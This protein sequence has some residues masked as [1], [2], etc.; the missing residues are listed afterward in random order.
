MTTLLSRKTARDALVVLFEATGLWEDVFGYVPKDSA[1]K[2]RSPIMFIT[3]FGTDQTMSGQQLN[4]ATYTYTVWSMVLSSTPDETQTESMAED[5]LDNLDRE[6]RQVVRDNSNQLGSNLVLGFSDGRSR[7]FFLP[8][9]G[10]KYIVE[11][12]Q[13]TVTDY[14]SA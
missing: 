12:F 2:G 9:G 14:G 11:Q 3:S 7:T 8:I 4:Q 5:D 10:E 13:I 6:V 1:V